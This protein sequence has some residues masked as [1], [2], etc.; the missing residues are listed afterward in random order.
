MKDRLAHH[1]ADFWSF[2]PQPPKLG[3]GSRD[4]AD[5]FLGSHLA[6]DVF[7]E[8]LGVGPITGE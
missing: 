6:V 8:Q 1:T 4:E 3:G 2:T 5:T 7:I